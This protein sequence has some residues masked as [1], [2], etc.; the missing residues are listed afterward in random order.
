MAAPGLSPN[1]QPGARFRSALVATGNGAGPPMRRWTVVRYDRD[2]VLA[3]VDLAELATEVC[4]PPRG[5]GPTARWH[6][7]NPDHPDAH[8]SMTVYRTARSARWKCHSCGDGGTAIDLVMTANSCGVREAMDV[9]AARSG[10]S[11]DTSFDRPTTH[12]PPVKARPSEAATASE[13]IPDEDRSLTAPDPCVEAYVAACA[14]I[15]W[16]D[17]GETGRNWLAARGFG[18]AVLRA[19]R[20]GFDPGPR[21]LRRDRGLPWRGAGVVYP[22]LAADQTAMYCQTR[23]LDPSAA[24]RPKYD[25]PLSAVAA[26]PRVAP[27]R[28]PELI[29]ELAPLVVVTEGI[30]DGLA[31]AHLG[32]RVAAVVGAA[33]HGPLVA[34]RLDRLYPSATF[35][36]VFDADHAGQR[37]G[38]L[39]GANLAALERTVV[40]GSPPPPDDLNT[41]WQTDH[42]RVAD[43]LAAAAIPCLSAHGPDLHGAAA[44][45]SPP[46][47]TVSR[48]SSG[49]RDVVGVGGT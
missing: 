11:P 6:C 13:D 44:H 14:E 15:L 9:L 27:L 2:E 41:W 24:G 49:A 29:P 34:A 8:P 7:P 18:D 36:I 22:V 30:P 42:E 1:V 40:L 5:R 43:A 33:N 12:P 20:V 4:G 23:Y 26:N 39:L 10:L 28:T 46:A 31:A 47:G 25:N 37:G 48:E 21:A 19:N 32:A 3:R 16:S 35:L 45:G 17:A 38:A